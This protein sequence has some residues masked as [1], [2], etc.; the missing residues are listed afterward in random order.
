MRL[1]I[2]AIVERAHVGDASGFDAGRSRTGH[3]ALRIYGWFADLAQP[4]ALT[5]AAETVIGYK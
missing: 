3:L 2:S 5:E 4:A 1:D